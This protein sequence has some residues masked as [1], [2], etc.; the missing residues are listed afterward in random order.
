MMW[1]LGHRLNYTGS[2]HVTTTEIKS[3]IHLDSTVRR[4]G[5]VHSCDGSCKVDLQRV[6]ISHS[7]CLLSG[8]S[9]KVLDKE[10]GYPP[11][12]G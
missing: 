9:Y 11:H 8:G 1:V 2:N 6:S 4:V 5:L 3:C 7:L 12:M 10:H